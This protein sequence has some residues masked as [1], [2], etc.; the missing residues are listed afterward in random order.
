MGTDLVADHPE[1]VVGYAPSG[2][3]LAQ[4]LRRH[5]ASDQE[6]IDA[7]LAKP[8]R[9]GKGIIDVFRDRLIL[10]IHNPGGDL[11]GF[12]GRARPDADKHVPK[13]LNTPTTRA[14]HKSEILFGLAEHQDLIKQGVDLVR[15]EGP[16][17]ALAITIGT[18]GKAIGVA[19]LGTALTEQQAQ[20]I[21]AQGVRVWEATD[22][23]AAGQK[24]AARDH[25]LLIRHGVVARD[26]PLLPPDGQPVK[27]PAELLQRDG[28][29][30]ALQMPLILE[31]AAPTVAGK[32]L[33]GMVAE[34]ADHLA[35]DANT[36]IAVAR[37]TAQ[38]IADLPTEER[39]YHTALVAAAMSD[40]DPAQHQEALRDLVTQ[41][42]QQHAQPD[43]DRPG[44]RIRP[45]AGEHLHDLATHLGVATTPP[46]TPAVQTPEPTPGAPLL[47][48]SLLPPLHTA[49]ITR[50]PHPVHDT[51][52]AQP[53]HTLQAMQ[54]AHPVQSAQQP[55]PEHPVQPVQPVQQSESLQD[56]ITR[57][58]VRQQ[59][60]ALAERMETL[61]ERAALTMDLDAAQRARTQLHHT[62]GTPLLQVLTAR[63]DLDRE[64]ATLEDR[65]HD[66]N[67]P[68]LQRSLE[69]HQAAVEAQRAQAIDAQARAI[70]ADRSRPLIDRIRDTA[71]LKRHTPQP[72]E[73]PTPPTPRRD[74]DAPER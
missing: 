47:P 66:L 29:A 73:Q 61:P 44:V 35:G 54:S 1:V 55:H 50:P 58:E 28:G 68:A 18:N 64:I 38:L 26:F 71:A 37:Q 70:A 7:G 34:H 23:D 40:A 49:A 22:T 48:A 21:A 45:R 33:V 8:A 74:H 16:L 12:V 62:P 36:R 72:P 42:V 46:H 52:P 6:L 63:A 20:A 19:P 11:V 53:L 59:L 39:D 24:A 56:I 5:G 57:W 32:L 41:E 3:R 65:L 43:P 15:V 9:D 10:G 2:S 51:Q 60:T 17:D 30:E 31:D 14:F 13:Y 67:K 25:E 27:D 69:R 4:H